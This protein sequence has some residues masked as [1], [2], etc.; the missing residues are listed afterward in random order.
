MSIL[1]MAERLKDNLLSGPDLF[2]LLYTSWLPRFARALPPLIS[3]LDA[4]MH[5]YYNHECIMILSHR[6]RNYYYYY[7]ETVSTY[8]CVSGV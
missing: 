1:R 6:Q 4:H 2:S 8:V 7:T 3:C 5:F